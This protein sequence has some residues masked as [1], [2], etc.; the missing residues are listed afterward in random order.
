MTFEAASPGKQEIR[1]AVQDRLR[2]M[3]AAT[4][5]EASAALC[6]QLEAQAVFQQAA[7]ILFYA[8]LK[9]EPDIWPLFLAARAAGKTVLL[10]RFVAEQGI[11]EAA[12]IAHPETDLQPGRHGVREPRMECSSFPL[13]RLD[14]GLCP[15]VAFTAQ[16]ARLGR[17][18][19]YYDRLL[20]QMTREK[21]GVSFDE[22]LVPALPV[23]AHDAF[24]GYIVTPTRWLTCQ[25]DG[26]MK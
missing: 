26:G 2:A 24:V 6:R 16:G 20:A 25:P 19:G 17:G 11:Y 8:P 5:A 12:V 14:L 13:N 23:E 9:M 10:P 4:R 15:G 18:G 21:C 3:T 22:Q 7:S 1:T